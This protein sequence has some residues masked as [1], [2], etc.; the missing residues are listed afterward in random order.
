MT[1]IHIKNTDELKTST[2]FEVDKKCYFYNEI[3]IIRSKY[4]YLNLQY[5]Y[6]VQILKLYM[7]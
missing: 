5:L 1:F 3:P 6:S 4:V 7:K 2:Y